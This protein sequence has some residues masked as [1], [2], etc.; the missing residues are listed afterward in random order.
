METDKCVLLNATM[1]IIEKDGATD[2]SDFGKIG[3][4]RAIT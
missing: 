4:Y 3:D 1:E 2:R